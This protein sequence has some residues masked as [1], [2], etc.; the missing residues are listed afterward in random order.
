MDQILFLA[1]IPV[2]LRLQL[3][4][5]LY[6]LLRFIAG[7]LVVDNVQLYSGL[8]VC[9]LFLFRLR[10]RVVLGPHFNKAGNV[11]PKKTFIIGHEQGVEVVGLGGDESAR[12][13]D[14]LFLLIDVFKVLRL[15]LHFET[16]AL[17]VEVE[18]LLIEVVEDGVG[19]PSQRVEE[20]V[21]L[22]FSAAVV[23]VVFE[24]L[25]FLLDHIKE[26]LLINQSIASSYHHRPQFNFS[27]K[28]GRDGHLELNQI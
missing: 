8:L 17:C 1:H 10:N 16:F 13:D 20:S 25:L 3:N 19:R 21:E 6:Y 26:I 14:F 12:V 4:S 7:I 5:P 9:H 22:L 28:I 27:F 11:L 24:L 23:D 15:V 18:M 2:L